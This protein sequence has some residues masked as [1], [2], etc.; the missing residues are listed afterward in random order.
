MLLEVSLA[1]HAKFDGSKLISEDSACL[2][3]IAILSYPRFS[4]REIIGP[5]SPR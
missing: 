5:T 3:M 2:W 1:G 4:K